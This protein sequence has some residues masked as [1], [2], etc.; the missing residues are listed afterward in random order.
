MNFYKT[1][2]REKFKHLPNICNKIKNIG[3]TFY[4]KAKI[5]LRYTITSK[6]IKY[7]LKMYI[8]M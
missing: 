3:D 8:K 7:T 6:L 5:K 2:T 4:V 1:N